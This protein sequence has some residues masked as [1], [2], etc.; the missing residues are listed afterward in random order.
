M[1][2]Q[3]L[4]SSS[5]AFRPALS[6]LW[7]LLVIIKFV[8]HTLGCPRT[9]VQRSADSMTSASGIHRRMSQT[10]YVPHTCVIQKVISYGYGFFFFWEKG[11]CTKR[12]P[13]LEQRILIDTRGR[14]LLLYHYFITVGIMFLKSSDKKRSKFNRAKS[15]LYVLVQFFCQICIFR[16]VYRK[17]RKIPLLFQ[18]RRIPLNFFE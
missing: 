16:Y 14:S 12:M 2:S 15:M 3:H 18:L 10:H 7:L 4:K 13:I 5:R 1:H 9:I 17:K 6:N 8:F 11:N